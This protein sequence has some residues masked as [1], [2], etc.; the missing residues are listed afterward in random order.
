[1]ARVQSMKW[2]MSA[3]FVQM[4]VQRVV[5]SGSYGQ[6]CC[7][8]KERFCKDQKR[9]QSARLPELVSMMHI[10]PGHF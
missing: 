5:S 9:E 6:R 4:N 1:M 3:L 2:K 7:A 8:Q 10:F